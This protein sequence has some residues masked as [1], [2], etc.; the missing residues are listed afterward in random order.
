MKT[1]F[2]PT[3]RSGLLKTEWFLA[4]RAVTQRRPQF[5][6]EDGDGA[7]ARH[8]VTYGS[9][10]TDEDPYLG[11]DYRCARAAVGRERGAGGHRGK[12]KLLYVQFWQLFLRDHTTNITS[13]FF[14]LF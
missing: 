11:K 2:F 6:L 4:L 1:F 3:C 10:S 7:F 8:D 9:R 14:S 13:V 12:K 5:F